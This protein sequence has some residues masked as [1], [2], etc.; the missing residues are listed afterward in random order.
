MAA[1]L[2]GGDGT[3]LSHISAARLRSL[4]IGPAIPVHVTAPRQTR[5][6]G[7]IAFHR[8][9]TSARRARPRSRDPGR[10]R[11]RARSSTW[12]R[13]SPSIDF[14]PRSTRLSTGGSPTSCRSAVFLERYPGAASC[15]RSALSWRRPRTARTE[16]T[17]SSSAVSRVPDR[18]RPADVPR[19][20][21]PLTVAGAAH[22]RRLRLVR[23]PGRSLELDG[24]AAHLRRRNFES[25]RERDP[26]LLVASW[27]PAR[28]TWRQ[29]E[30][31]PGELERDLRALLGEN[32]VSGRITSESIT[33]E[34]GGPS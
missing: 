23:A 5:L 3:A 24:V 21:H 11:R 33:L 28:A 18:A 10:P 19:F 1:V 2:A 26:P 13:A 17:V 22:R 8:S 4:P 34:R 6:D 14:G 9:R 30:R 25:D 7:D 15:A 32:V 12:R 31:A 29:L 20:N 16:R 27:R